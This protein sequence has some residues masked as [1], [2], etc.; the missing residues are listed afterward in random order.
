MAGSDRVRAAGSAV[1]LTYDDFVKFPDDGKW[2]ELILPCIVPNFEANP[3]AVRRNQRPR[4]SH[5]GRE[6]S[7]LVERWA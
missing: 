1:K 4:V 5:G 7:P 6:R 3:S 2:H